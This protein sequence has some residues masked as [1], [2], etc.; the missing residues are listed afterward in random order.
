MIGEMITELLKPPV[1]DMLY[2][3]LADTLMGVFMPLDCEPAHALC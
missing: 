3:I 2:P 1:M